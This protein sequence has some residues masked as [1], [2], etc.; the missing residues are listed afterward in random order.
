MFSIFGKEG[1]RHRLPRL[2]EATEVI[3]EESPDKLTPEKLLS[4]HLMAHISMALFK[5]NPK[6][7]LFDNVPE[8]TMEDIEGWHDAL[9]TEME[10]RGIPH[11]TPKGA[12]DVN[13][14]D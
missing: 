6:H 4:E 8:L 9:A 7:Y 1:F 10:R 13:Q 5:R 12:T 14:K 3:T 2:C 11:K